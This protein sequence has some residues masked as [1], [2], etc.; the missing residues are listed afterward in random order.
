MDAITQTSDMRV[1]RYPK[2]LGLY[3]ET[4]DKLNQIPSPPRYVFDDKTI[5]TATELTLVDQKYSAK[6]WIASQFHIL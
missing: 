6:Q 3:K 1:S 5:E 2:E 4:S